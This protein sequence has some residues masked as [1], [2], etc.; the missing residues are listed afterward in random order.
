MSIDVSKLKITYNIF[1]YYTLHV[2]NKNNLIAL[3]SKLKNFIATVGY[4]YNLIIKF[5]ENIAFEDIEMIGSN[6]IDL[7]DKYNIKIYAFDI[8]ENFS[9]NSLLGINVINITENNNKQSTFTAKTLNINEPVRSGVK[10]FNEGDIVVTSFVSPGAE[11]IATGN[12]HI[13]GELKGKAIAGANGD[14]NC[15][16]FVNRFDPELVSIAGYYR[17]FEE[18]LAENL[19]NKSVIVELD[20]NKRINVKII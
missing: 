2:V 3:E 9:I 8:P 5:S 1:E 11:I 19:Y 18:K 7:C 15:K 13:Y 10:I 16:I 20:N 17:V 6:I 14:V 4:N 12:I